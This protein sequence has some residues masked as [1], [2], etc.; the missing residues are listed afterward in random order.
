MHILFGIVRPQF[1]PGSTF[2]MVLQKIEKPPIFTLAVVMQ[3]GVLD[4]SVF[5]DEGFFRQN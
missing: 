5:V 1:L 4:K 3:E 2:Q